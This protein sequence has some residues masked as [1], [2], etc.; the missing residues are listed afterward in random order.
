MKNF[1]YMAPPRSH[2]NWGKV[3]LMSESSMKSYFTA[4]EKYGF[5][6]KHKA[7]NHNNQCL[8]KYIFPIPKLGSTPLIVKTGKKSKKGKI[9]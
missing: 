3:L 1:S 4:F 2:I 8:I 5:I 7:P 9:K 6:I